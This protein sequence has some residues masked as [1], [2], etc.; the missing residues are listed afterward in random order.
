[1]HHNNKCLL[2]EVMLSTGLLT[3]VLSLVGHV[4]A[5]LAHYIE[6][7]TQPRQGQG[8]GFNFHDPHALEWN[9]WR[10]L[11]IWPSWSP[12][13]DF[14][15]FFFNWKKEKSSWRNLWVLKGFLKLWCQI[16][17]RTHPKCLLPNW[18]FIILFFWITD[19]TSAFIIAF[20]EF[21]IL[22]NRKF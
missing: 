7:P 18:I 15:F 22:S 21:Q 16:M 20:G 19:C 4:R 11:Q 1:M 17:S 3:T 9:P 6:S 2:W 10:L 14:L 8:C 13:G 5:C 12:I